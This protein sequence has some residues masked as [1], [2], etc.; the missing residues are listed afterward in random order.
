MVCG[1]GSIWRERR[2]DPCNV[3][4]YFLLVSDVWVDFVLIAPFES[5]GV[6]VN[7]GS[8]VVKAWQR[9]LEAKNCHYSHLCDRNG[10][11]VGP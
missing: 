10:E 5:V 7:V 4:Y 11:N 8:G 6:D 2:I 9:Q 1:D 3:H